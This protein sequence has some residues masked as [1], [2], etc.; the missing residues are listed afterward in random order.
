MKH[1]DS[2]SIFKRTVCGALAAL[3]IL[4]C[5]CTGTD[6]DSTFGETTSDTHAPEITVNDVTEPSEDTSSMTEITETDDATTE[7]GNDSHT[8]VFTSETT[9]FESIIDSTE[10]DGITTDAITDDITTDEVTTDAITTA[11]KPP[12]P[13]EKTSKPVIVGTVSQASDRVIIYGTTE[14][15][16]KIT[17]KGQK[18]SPLTDKA[19]GHNFYVEVNGSKSDVITLY[20][21]ADGKT[22]SDP[23]TVEVSFGGEKT[24]VFAGRNS[25]LFYRPTVSFMFGSVQA[26]SSILKYT[27]NRLNSV[28]KEVQKRTGKDT[29]LIYLIAPN[30]VTVY[31]DE[32]YDYLLNA[33]GGKQHPTA[34][35]QFVAY[36][37][38]EGKNEDIIVPDL[39]KVFNQHKDEMIYFSTDTHWSELGA[40]Y[41]YKEMMG[42]INK[43]F[44]SAKA[45]E[46]SE[47]DIKTVNCKGGDLRS[48][49]HANDMTEETPFLIAKFT[50]TG[51]VYPIKRSDDIGYRIAGI[52]W[53]LYPKNSY[54]NNSSLPTAYALS[55]SYGAYFLPFAGMG[56]SHLRLHGANN[57]TPIDI[58]EIA[59]MKPDYIIFNY[60]DRNIDSNLGMIIHLWSAI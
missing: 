57:N 56:F 35:A 2:K 48:M 12:K 43:D 13:T 27:A 21:T 49:L 29:K 44:P 42:Y 17:Y 37:N 36:M 6:S 23:I 59:K 51:D 47:F 18:S 60:T 38:G 54:I 4:G 22:A 5:A 1:T 9:E 46:L 28:L 7:N 10:T 25:R 52:N 8:D 19:S 33:T 11:P 31:A 26:S 58:N 16:A 20:A 41:A 53:G 24:D 50:D 32:Q 34:G 3:C 40:Y 14:Y 39:L 55:D 30:P 45:H 15:G